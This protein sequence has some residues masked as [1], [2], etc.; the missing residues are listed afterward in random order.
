M[1]T[2]WDGAR[3]V[4]AALLLVTPLAVA[5]CEAHDRGRPAH[6]TVIADDPRR[7]PEYPMK[8]IGRVRFRCDLPGAES[9]TMTVRLEE[10]VD[11]G[12]PRVQRSEARGQAAGILGHS[13]WTTVASETFTRTGEATHAE[14]FE[15]RSVQVK[16]RCAEGRF[17]TTVSWC[18]TSR[19]DVAEGGFRSGAIR[20]PCRHE[21]SLLDLG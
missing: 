1:T 11:I 16:T 13:A 7:H 20:D 6:C 19:G 18:R 5:G 17:R 10:Q 4:V 15:Y 8:L 9:L 3:R 14:F 21:P 2:S 12:R